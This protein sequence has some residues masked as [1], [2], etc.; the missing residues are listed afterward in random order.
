MK[1]EEID[2]GPVLRIARAVKKHILT[3][4]RDNKPEDVNVN[5]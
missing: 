3:K 4:H 1:Q 2:K 5:K